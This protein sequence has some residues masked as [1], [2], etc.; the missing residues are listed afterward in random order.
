MS[1]NEFSASPS[2]AQAI[3]TAPEAPDG[4]RLEVRHCGNRVRLQHLARRPHALGP[5]PLFHYLDEVECGRDLREHLE[6]YARL[7]LGV[8]AAL[9][10]THFGLAV[11]VIEG[12]GGHEQA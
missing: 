8:V 4:A 9:G 1:T 10:G 2:T 11:F 5:R 6:T 12:D 7:D 3:I